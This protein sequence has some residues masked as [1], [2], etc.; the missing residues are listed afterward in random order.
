MYFEFRSDKSVNDALL[1]NV[2]DPWQR[3]PDT[4]HLEDIEGII[5]GRRK[6]DVD[7]S[8]IYPILQALYDESAAPLASSE[9]TQ[10]ATVDESTN[11]HNQGSSSSNGKP[12]TSKSAAGK[13]L[14]KPTF[15]PW[16]KSTAVVKFTFHGDNPLS[17][18]I[19]NTWGSV[20]VPVRDLVDVGVADDVAMTYT[21]KTVWKPIHWTTAHIQ[22]PA[23]LY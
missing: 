9:A 2:S 16:R 20:Q 18:F 21:E 23:S 22:V 10:T 1:H 5:G 6:D 17:S 7:I 19:D 14:A 15:V 12:S 4:M 8:Y 13:K 3:N 11:G